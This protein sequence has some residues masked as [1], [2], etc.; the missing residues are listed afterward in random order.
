MAT[1]RRPKGTG[2][3]FQECTPTCPPPVVTVDA[4]GKRT[5]AR[6][7]H[8]C[9]G[10][11][12]GTY[13]AGWTKRG[14]R[15]RPKVTGAT[16]TIV[17][18]KL[19]KKIREQEEAEAPTVGGKPTVKRW[20][21]AWLEQT[22]AHLRPH[23]WATDRSQVVNHVVPV[24]GHRQLGQLGP[25][26]IRAVH[27]AMHVGG[28]A[29]SSISRCHAVL[30]KM[31]RDA[32]LAGHKVPQGALLVDGPDLGRSDRDAILLDDAMAILTAAAQRPDSS[33]WAMALLQGMRPA[34]TLGLT[35]DMVNLDGEEP[36][37]TV[38]WQLKPLP[39]LVPR[40]R[41][42]GFRVPIGFEAR[43]LVGSLHLVRPKTSA[44]W[45]VVPLVPWMAASLA[46]WREIAPASPH[47]LVWPQANGRPRIDKNDRAEW[48]AIA[49][50]ARV[51]WV[52]G[53]QG[54]RYPL[55]AARHT[56]ATVLR[57]LRV[58]NE[59]IEEIM[60]HASILSTQAYLHTDPARKRAALEGVAGKLGLGVVSQP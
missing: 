26:D 13:E 11:W 47:G 39:Y 38:A 41:D 3:V 43:Q 4:D 23:T 45:R 52:E 44:G 57:Q 5:K 18:Q 25:A 27:R 7:K 58:D 46:A 37:M 9:P 20:A 22:Q 24:I 56:T 19:L 14:T 8:K 6:P 29:P 36:S 42:S 15:R 12:V 17:R 21:D 34:E 53:T 30:G 2:T 60:G 48:F 51:A 35:W 55:Y 50:E 28:S 32:I 16:A 33:R 1:A 59:T 54:C 40:K 49:D 31:L 10:R